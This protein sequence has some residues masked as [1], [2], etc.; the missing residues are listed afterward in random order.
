MIVHG[1]ADVIS[2]LS[3]V[4]LGPHPSYL[5]KQSVKAHLSVSML[6]KKLVRPFPTSTT[7]FL[8]LYFSYKCPTVF[9]FGVKDARHMVDCSMIRLSLT[10]V[11]FPL[12][13]YKQAKSL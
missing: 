13:H 8:I 12:V 11:Y 6:S 3:P 7:D 5:M 10:I 1:R 4:Y 9:Y 2:I